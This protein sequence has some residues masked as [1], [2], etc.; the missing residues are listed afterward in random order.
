MRRP[1]KLRF[2]DESDSGFGWI[3]DEF[4]ERCSHAL[5]LNGRVWVIDPVDGAGVEERIRAAGRPAAVIQL[6]GRHRRDS[7][8]MAKR[9]GVPLH[10]LPKTPVEGAPFEFLPVPN[11]RLGT[12][13]ALWWPGRRLLLAADVV[14]TARVYRAGGE[15]LGVHPFLRMTPPRAQLGRLRPDSILCGHGEGLLA[16]ASPVLAE[17]LS[18]A[19]R[20]ILLLPSSTVRALRGARSHDG[21]GRH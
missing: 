10:K 20:R 1:A 2:C 5:V 14:G 6:L 19:R 11:G 21:L 13:A 15:R 9:L 17:A 7:A 8:A 3:V 18:T 4:L 16:D 12:E